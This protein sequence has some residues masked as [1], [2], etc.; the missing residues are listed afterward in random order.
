[1][2][3]RS[4]SNKIWG[5]AV[6]QRRW[7]NSWIIPVQGPTLDAK[8]DPMGLNRLASSVH[9][10]FVMAS[11]MVEKAVSCYGA[12][13]LVA[14]LLSFCSVQSSLAVREFHAAGEECCKRGHGRVCDA[15]CRGVQ[16]ASE[17]FQLCE[18]SGPTFRYAMQ[19]FSLLGCYMEN[20]EKL[21]KL[22]GGACPGQYSHFAGTNFHE[23]IKRCILW[24]K[25]LWSDMSSFL[26]SAQLTCKTYECKYHWRLS[27]PKADYQLFGWQQ[28]ESN[29]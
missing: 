4:S 25:V 5:W 12:D 24:I 26:F 8:L 16:S 23:L 10:C 6:T 19:E 29:Y 1:M 22:V 27:T 2:G 15:W 9:L 11:P 28:L 17:Q 3:T 20:S 18:L 13:Q 14:S 7:L 21:S